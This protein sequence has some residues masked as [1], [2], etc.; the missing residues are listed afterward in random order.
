MIK[1]TIQLNREVRKPHLFNKPDS[2]GRKKILLWFLFE[3]EYC[4]LAGFTRAIG[5]CSISI[6]N[7]EST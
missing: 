6:Y 5:A 3:L 1:I 7:A 2:S 4:A